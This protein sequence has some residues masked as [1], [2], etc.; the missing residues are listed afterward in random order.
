MEPC[1]LTP[2]PELDDLKAICEN[3][4]EKTYKLIPETEPIPV[5]ELS[6]RTSECF[7]AISSLSK[8]LVV[9]NPDFSKLDSY[10]HGKKNRYSDVL[11]YDGCRCFVG[12]ERDYINMSPMEFSGQIYLVSQGP[13]SNTFADFWKVIL[14]HKVDTIVNLA[15][16]VEGGKS[17]CYD[18]WNL[19]NNINID[20]K[21][22]ALTEEAVVLDQK[23]SQRLVERL[24]QIYKDGQPQGKVKQLHL[25]NWPDYGVPD[26]DLLLKLVIA[27]KQTKN[28]MVVHC[29]AGIGRSGVV[30]MAARLISEC[31]EKVDLVRLGL[32]M[33]LHRE[34]MIATKE[35]L[36]AAV[37]TYHK[38][39]Q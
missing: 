24:I 14:Q 16:P 36:L 7:R 30:V 3:W 15:M 34:G 37:E 29:S 1:T 4:R 23:G 32:E 17:R 19:S 26:I 6:L 38:F 28:P 27:A 25:E 33:R 5:D 8:T 22:H 18:Y 10:F 13:L 12:S 2:S 20:Q 11:P 9:N 39:K 35:Q 31:A 21:Y